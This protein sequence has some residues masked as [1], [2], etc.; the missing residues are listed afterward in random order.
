MQVPL[1]PQFL[2]A[3]LRQS[4]HTFLKISLPWA[5][6]SG[7]IFFLGLHIGADFQRTEDK[8]GVNLGQS[9][10]LKKIQNL[11]KNQE[12]KPKPFKNKIEKTEA[13]PPMPPN[14]LRIMQGGD[15]VERL[16][17]FLDAVRSMDQSNVGHV[18]QAFEELPGGYGRHLEMKLL[19]RSWANFDPKGALTYATTKLDAKSE[20]AFGISE[21]LAGWVAKDEKAAIAWAKDNHP[22]E[23]QGDNPLLT[24][25]VKGLMETDLEAANRLFLSLPKG[26]ARWQ[27]SSLLADKYFEKDP[28]RSIEWADQF[29]SDDPLMRETILSQIGSKLAKHDLELAANWVNS[30]QDEPGTYR[31]LDNLMNQWISTDPSAAAFWT[32]RIQ[33][34]KKKRYAMNQLSKQWSAVDPIATAKW[35]NTQPPSAESDLAISN[36]VSVI[37]QSDP[38]GAI[39]WAQSIEEPGLRDQSVQHVLKTW[40]VQDAAKANKWLKDNNPTK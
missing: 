18:L 22:D 30:M 27:S 17:S 38:Q 1:A 6:S 3:Y 15:I 10:D 37:S 32:E 4:M 24:G 7:V 13:T 31:V 5:V 34:L 2:Q 40:Q 21:A 39:E 14:L 12:N 25:I 19:M 8:N 23:N 20:R 36:F 29:P 11:K 9:F 16:G 33:N 26:S 35:L 28:Q